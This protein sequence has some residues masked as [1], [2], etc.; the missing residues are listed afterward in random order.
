[1]Y[2]VAFLAISDVFSIAKIIKYYVNAS[3]GR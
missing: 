3:L 1:M 2:R